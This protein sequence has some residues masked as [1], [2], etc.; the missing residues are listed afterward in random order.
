MFNVYDNFWLADDNRVFGS[1]K[2]IISD[3]SDPDY[4][5]WSNSFFASPWPRDGAGNQTNA[6]LQDVLTPYNLFIDLVYYTANARWLWQTGG[7]TVAGETYLTDRVSGN[8]RNVAY[9]Y[10]QANPA[11]TFDWK[12]PNGT[13]VA[14]TAAQLTHV[15]ES[16]AGFVQS[17]FTCEQNTVA[18]ITGGTITTRAQVDAAFSAI[19]NVFA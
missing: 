2:Q 12:L 14:L 7:I 10:A 18:S 1:A 5:A 13:F 15:A 16:E 8:E 17:C 19:S 6:A 4:V 9:N 3:T 11:T